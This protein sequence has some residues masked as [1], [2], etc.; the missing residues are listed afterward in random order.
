MDLF[1]FPKKI[2]SSRHEENITILYAS[3]PPAMVDLVFRGGR[4][5]VSTV[6]KTLAEICHVRLRASNWKMY[7]ELYSVF[8]TV[9]S[10]SI[11]TQHSY[12]DVGGYAASGA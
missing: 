8:I 3:C 6:I 2:S 11:V 12:E 5:Q 10:R 1:S 4:E 7:E 9:F